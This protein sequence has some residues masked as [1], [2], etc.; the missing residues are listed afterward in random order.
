MFEIR[1]INT[2]DAAAALAVYAPYVLTTAYTFEYEVPTVA[3]FKKKIEKITAQHPWLVCEYN[4]EIIGYAYGSTQHERP[5]YQWTTET[6]IYLKPDFH[7]KGIARILYTALFNI[8]KLQGYYTLYANVLSTNIGSCK[9]HKAMGFEEIGI[10]RNIGYKLGQWQSNLGMQY[11]LQE[12][13][14]EP[15]APLPIS[16]IKNETVL[17]SILLYAN[18]QINT[19]VNHV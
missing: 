3:D 1:L 6:T 11:F 18:E 7:G 9:F 5:G 2:S 8:L 16:S 4:G 13:N 12:H 15:K 14:K 10:Y 17:A 19:A